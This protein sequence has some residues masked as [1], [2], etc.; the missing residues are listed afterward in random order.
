MRKCPRSAQEEPQQVGQEWL[1]GE[2][3][4]GAEGGRI[5]VIGNVNDRLFQ[6]RGC[7]AESPGEEL[8]PVLRRREKKVLEGKAEGS[9]RSTDLMATQSIEFILQDISD[10]GREMR[11][12]ASQEDKRKQ[13]WQSLQEDL[14]VQ[15]QSDQ[16]FRSEKVLFRARGVFCTSLR[17]RSLPSPASLFLTYSP[18]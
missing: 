18:C 6:T 1:E 8:T 14:A 17:V 9:H 4:T 3:E 5:S 7:W 12:A 16:G 2:D 11:K 15:S 10:Q 13:E